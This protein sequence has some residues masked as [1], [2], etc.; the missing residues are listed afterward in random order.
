MLSLGSLSIEGHVTPVL[1]ARGGRGL[2]WAETDL[3]PPEPG[4]WQHRSQSLS[5]CSVS[6]FFIELCFV[7]AAVYDVHREGPE[8]HNNNE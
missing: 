6:Y 5:T 1:A 4:F 2:S 7:A 8:V 3:V